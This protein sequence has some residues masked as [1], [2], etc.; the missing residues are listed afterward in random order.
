M[1]SQMIFC[2]FITTFTLFSSAHAQEQA[3]STV[4]PTPTPMKNHVEHRFTDGFFGMNQPSTQGGQ[5]YNFSTLR[6]TGNLTDDGY[7]GGYRIENVEVEKQIDGFYITKLEERTT[8]KKLQKY[9]IT[10]ADLVWAPLYTLYDRA[11]RFSVQNVL[12]DAGLEYQKSQNLSF[13]ATGGLGEIMPFDIAN[14]ILSFLPAYT[15]EGAVEYSKES[16]DILIRLHWYQGKWSKHKDEPDYGIYQE[17][18]AYYGQAEIVYAHRLGKQI[19]LLASTEWRMAS[20]KIQQ[21]ITPHDPTQP[22]QHIHLNQAPSNLRFN[23]GIRFIR[24]Y[25]KRA[26]KIVTPIE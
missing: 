14:T 10:K 5:F 9:G 1:R 3:T 11:L 16:N 25:R 22:M 21:D 2:L 19:D 4:T 8:S 6:T 7:E 20:E 23:V 26:A 12:L 17:V 18:Q 15:V 13:R 24:D